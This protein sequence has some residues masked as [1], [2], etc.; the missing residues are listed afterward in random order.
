MASLFRQIGIYAP[1]GQL[2]EPEDAGSLLSY[3]E[4][5]D[6]QL[7]EE[8]ITEAGAVSSWTAAA[9]AYSVHGL[10]MLPFYIYYSMFGFQRVGDLIWAAADQRARGFLIGAT[11]GRTTLAGEGLQHQD[12]ASHVMA[13][14]TPNCRAYDPAYA[15][16]L[17]VIID[18]G[19]RRMIEAQ[20]DEFFY[21]TVINESYPQP[22][23]PDGAEAGIVAGLYRV[24]GPGAESGQARVRL[25]GSGTILREAIAAAESLAE[26]WNVSSDVFSATSFA[27]LARGVS[28]LERWNR[29]HPGETAARR[30]MS[31]GCSPARAGGSGRR[32]RPRL[33]ATRRGLPR[34]ALRGAGNQ[35]IRAQ[36]HARR[37][38]PVLRGRPAEHRARGAFCACRGGDASARTLADAIGRYGVDRTP[39]RRGH[40]ETV[41]ASVCR[42]APMVSLARRFRRRRAGRAAEAQPDVRVVLRLAL[43]ERI[44]GRVPGADVVGKVVEHEVAAVGLDGQHRVA[45]AAEVAHD[46]HQ[47][48][49]AGEAALDQELPLEQRIHLAV[50]L[51][52]D[53]IVPVV[54]QGA[55]MV[56]V[57][58]RLD[59]AVGHGVDVVEG[60]PHLAGHVD[61]HRIELAERAFLGVPVAEVD[62]AVGMVVSPPTG[63]KLAFGRPSEASPKPAQ[64]RPTMTAATRKLRSR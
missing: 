25:L 12:G 37:A 15:Y 56:E 14:L 52:V 21:V 30:A 32:L 3:R 64:A 47:Q 27:E 57:A 22:S 23:M 62:P 50:A 16:E 61:V 38:A 33:P 51:A 31:R 20:A 13:A 59:H 42:A 6:G 45:F 8:G 46:R 5:K 36:R 2:Y 11:A 40:A 9:T 7:L 63:V 53:R 10:T 39:R 4:A 44:A 19:L 58:D 34:C 1:E 60:L 28:E 26:D 24:G 41:T 55:P 35:P 29:L 18:H 43:E 54:E 48:R 17:A 49:L